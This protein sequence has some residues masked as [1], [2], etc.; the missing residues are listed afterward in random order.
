MSQ[1][2][3]LEET[4]LIFPNWL[5]LVTSYRVMGKRTH[6]T[7]LMAVMKIHGITQV[8]TFNSDDFIKTPE[9]IIVHPNQVI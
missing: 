7:R 9:I 4:P 8:L 1:L 6:D 2:L 3:L 5:Q